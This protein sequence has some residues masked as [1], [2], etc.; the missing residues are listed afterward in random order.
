M[1]KQHFHRV[2]DSFSVMFVITGLLIS[3][4]TFAAEQPGPLAGSEWQLVEFQSMDDAIGTI[5]PDDPSLY[6]MRLGADGIVSM[7]LNCNRATGDWLAEPSA[8]GSGG[9]F[10]F[11]PLAATSAFCPPPSMDERITKDAGYVR[12]YLLKDG[13]LYLSLMADAG[14]YAWEPLAV[15]S[16]ESDD[17]ASPDD[18]GPRNWQVSGISTALNMRAEASLQAKVLKRLPDG[19]ILDNLG[20]E[21][22]GEIT[23]C[24]VQEFGGGMRG[25]VSANF[26]KPAVSPD[27]SV[28]RGPDL[29]AERAG[30]GK[31]DATGTLPCA[32]GAGQPLR[33]CDF[34]V[35][36]TGG[37]YSTVVVKK[38]YGGSRAIFFRMGVA[39]GADTSEADGYLE[40]SVTRENDL[41]RV[42]VG[43]ERYEIPDAVVL[44]G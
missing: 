15:N 27:G 2:P 35:A 30:K 16:G 14:I 44:G 10:R 26:L 24:D 38:P 31:F 40:F 32:E 1:K 42:Q 36:R 13:N 3:S 34:G 25:Y 9:S 12:G 22:I 11:G 19:A 18:G 20:C 33:E 7:Q 6:T 4:V 29:S 37:G 23:W 43:S 21:K 5:R 39:V 41:N 28:A 8:D 17:Y